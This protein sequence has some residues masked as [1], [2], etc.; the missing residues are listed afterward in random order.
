MRKDN[1]ELVV[2]N[3]P[4]NKQPKFKP[5]NC[6]SCKQDMW[7]DFD[8]EYYW[9][10]CEYIINKQKHQIDKKILR[11]DQYFSATLP[12]VYKKIREISM[13]MVNTTYNST[14]DMINKLQELKGK[15]NLELYKKLGLYYE[16]MNIT[17][18]KFQEDPLNKNAQ[19]FIKISHEVIIILIFLHTKP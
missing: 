12:F 15:T 8:K 13:N 17:N 18:F 10:N 9:Q 4:K 11:Q 5:P 1:E 19:S 3:Y 6:P 16:E 14:D 7:L 2:K